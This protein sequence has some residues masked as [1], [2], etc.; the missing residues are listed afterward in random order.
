[1]THPRL[2]KVMREAAAGSDGLNHPDWLVA[3]IP[4]HI[5]ERLEAALEGCAWHDGDCGRPAGHEWHWFHWWHGRADEHDPRWSCHP[6]V[7]L[8]DLP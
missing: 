7:P 4:E 2:V 3:A 1:M 5:A 8:V 6:Y